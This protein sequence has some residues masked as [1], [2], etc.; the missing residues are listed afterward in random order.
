MP[1]TVGA[2][3]GNH[4]PPRTLEHNDRIYEARLFEKRHRAIIERWMRTNAQQSLL[5]LK[6]FADAAEWKRQWDE[7][8]DRIAGGAY[9]FFGRAC[10][11]AMRGEAG[12]ILMAQLVFGVGEDEMLTLF[13]E[14]GDEVRAIL[15]E[16]YAESFPDWSQADADPNA[17]GG[18]VTT[19][20]PPEP[21]RE[22]ATE[23]AATG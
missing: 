19:P 14:R 13:A 1:T 15:H 7:L 21:T 6:P 20:P 11:Q 23:T 9:S 8:T 16:V 12:G 10:R 2:Q 5:E 4:A 3:A 18:E 17:E 22:S